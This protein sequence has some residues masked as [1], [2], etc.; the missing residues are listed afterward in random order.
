MVPER[1]LLWAQAK[2]MNL[3]RFLTSLE[4]IIKKLSAGLIVM[5]LI[6]I[7]GLLTPMILIKLVRY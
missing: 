1:L 6:E 7:L 3:S 2:L 4:R 5:M